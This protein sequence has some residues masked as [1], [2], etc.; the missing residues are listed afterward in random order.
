MAKKKRKSHQ[1]PRTRAASAGA[2]KTA[3]R[4]TPHEKAPSAPPPARNARAEKKELARQQREQVRKRIQRAERARRLMWIAGIGTVIALG[5]FWFTRPNEPVERPDT[6]PGELTSEAP[7]PANA[8]EAA[9]RADAIG[10]PPEGT[11]QH[12]HAN[13]QVFVHGERQTVPTDI[14]ID[15]SARE[16]L[17]LHTHEDSGTI[18][19][20]SQTRRAFTLGE[21]FDVW[22][23][24]LDGDCLG[25]YCDDDQNRLWVFVDGEEASGPPRDVVLDD[26]AVIVLA[27]G[28]EEE[29]PDPIPS[30]FDF[31]SVP[32]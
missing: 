27:Y 5:V 10:L 4:T 32:Q 25:A 13:V 12:T 2:V 3:E 26:E 8:S 19:V 7:W 21:F 15:Q 11:T 30:V 9:A 31:A 17:S 28:T 18:H 1:R 14:G 6:L 23:V 16:V 20:E 22:G 24:R 29:L